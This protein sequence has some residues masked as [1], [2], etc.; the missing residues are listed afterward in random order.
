MT[1]KL[2]CIFLIRTGMQNALVL[3]IYWQI[4]IMLSPAVSCSRQHFHNIPR[5]LLP[6]IPG[7]VKTGLST[8]ALTPQSE[9]D[10]LGMPTEAI[11]I[12]SA[13]I[14]FLSRKRK[15]CTLEW[16]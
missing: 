10:A 3:L 2:H 9:P 13:K 8:F 4:S 7:F 16:T 1:L 5:M 15:E 14:S 11:T 6:R 12:A